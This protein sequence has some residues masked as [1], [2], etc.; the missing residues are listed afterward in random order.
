VNQPPRA[1]LLDVEGTTTPIDFVVGTLFPLALERLGPYLGSHG[2]HADVR[3]HVLD[4]RAAWEAEDPASGR[5]PWSSPAD[6]RAA[7]ATYASWLTHHDRKVTALKA[8]QGLVWAHEYRSG[9]LIAPVYDDVAP[10]LERWARRGTPASIFSSGSVLAQRMLFE[11]TSSGDLTGLLCEFFDTT[12]GPKREATSYTA[13][14]AKL[15]LAPTD[16]LF[17]SDTTAEL[18][19]ARDA[20]MRTAQCVRPGAAD[21]AS[22]GSHRVIHSFAQLE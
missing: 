20:G 22:A 3:A 17:A 8:L 14:A 15:D 4:L 16:L 5:P 18:D 10:A 19:A 12:I 1:V 21:M 13:I 6:D 7:A 11:H 2:D 9:R